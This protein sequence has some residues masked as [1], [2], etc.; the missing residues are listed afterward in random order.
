MY[1]GKNPDNYPPLWITFVLVR[2]NTKNVFAYRLFVRKVLLS[3]RLIDD[4]DAHTTRSITV[5]KIATSD[6]GNSHR[7]K[8]VGADGAN[9][10]RWLTSRCGLRMSFDS[11]VTA[12]VR[13]T[14]R[15]GRHE[16]CALAAGYRFQ[17]RDGWTYIL[18]AR[19]HLIILR[20]C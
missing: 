4:G 17:A 15:H 3:Q 19:R 6:Q 10:C 18:Q 2:A 20:R 1:V 11:E 5:V 12:N 16:R 8:I 9:V 7:L 13:T 14:E